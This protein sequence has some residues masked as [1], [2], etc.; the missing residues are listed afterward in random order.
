MIGRVLWGI[1]NGLLA[2]AAIRL[3][4]GLKLG[5][6]SWL[7]RRAGFAILRAYSLGGGID[8]GI[9]HLFDTW[10]EEGRRC[11]THL[12]EEGRVPPEHQFVAELLAEDP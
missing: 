11:L 3:N 4:R 9:A 1:L 6:D 12:L 10:G 8:D 5:P 7:A 2:D